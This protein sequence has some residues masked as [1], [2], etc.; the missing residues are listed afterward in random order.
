MAKPINQT[1]VSIICPYRNAVAFLPALVENVQRQTY[2]NWE[3]LLIDDGSTDNGPLFAAKAARLDPRIRALSAPHRP[4]GFSK[5]PWWPRNVG[6]RNTQS[7]LI[8]FLDVDDLWHPLKL[9]H[10]IFS[11]LN[12]SASLSVTGYARFDYSSRKVLALRSPPSSFGYPRLRKS[13]V[14][15]MLSALVNR[16][17]LVEEFRPC[18]HEDYLFWLSLLRA[19]PN[20]RCISIPEVLAFYSVHEANLSRSKWMMPLWTYRVYR[21]HGMSMLGSCVALVPWAL[22]QL[23][24]N[25]PSNHSCIGLPVEQLMSRPM[26]VSLSQKPTSIDLLASS[27]TR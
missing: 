27:L 25:H 17:L 15:P 9:Q 26:P 10:Q 14:V 5:G 11:H 19:N 13:N 8:A 4:S 22:S 21:L 7:E 23:T 12:A 3:L 1:Q 2:S 20:S 18:P 24:I 16:S 6:L